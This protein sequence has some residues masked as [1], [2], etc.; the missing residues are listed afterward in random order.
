MAGFRVLR[1][2][3]SFVININPPGS[4]R[5]GRNVGFPVSGACN[6]TVCRDVSTSACKSAKNVTLVEN[7]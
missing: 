7:L 1:P 6:F 3:Y 4:G 5:N 2:H